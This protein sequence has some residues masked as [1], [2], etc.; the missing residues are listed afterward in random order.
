MDEFDAPESIIQLVKC[1]WKS[2]K[3]VTEWCTTVAHNIKFTNLS[4]AQMKI[5]TIAGMWTFYQLIKSSKNE[6][7]VS[8]YDN[9]HMEK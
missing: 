9:V 1:N 4:H 2:V 7:I 5:S 3:D 6:T 8:I